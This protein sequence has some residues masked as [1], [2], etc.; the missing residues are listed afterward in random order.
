GTWRIVAPKRAAAV[1]LG[2]K[3][4]FAQFLFIG[5]VGDFRGDLAWDDGHAIRVADYDVAG[6]HG[7]AGAADWLLHCNG[8]VIGRPGRGG[9]AAAIAGE[10]HGRNFG[11]IAE[12][13]IG[14]GGS[15]TL[16]HHARHQHIAS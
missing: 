12:G 1:D 7:Y 3:E 5:I 10:R 16:T 4:F 15:Y 6:V 14:N 2:E 11:A 8:A 9:I 13:A